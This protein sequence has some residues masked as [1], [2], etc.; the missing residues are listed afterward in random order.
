MCSGQVVHAEINKNR[1]G[2]SKG[3]GTVQFKTPLEAINA[4]CILN[5]WDVFMVCLNWKFLF[6]LTVKLCFMVKCC[7]TVQWL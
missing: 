7:L 2:K 1:D 6:S 4:V 3:N 5:H